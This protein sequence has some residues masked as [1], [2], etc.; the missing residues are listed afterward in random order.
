M[1]FILDED[2][3]FIITNEKG[4]EEEYLYFTA[5]TTNSHGGEEIVI[6]RS[7]FEE[8]GARLVI[9]VEITAGDRRDEKQA[10]RNKHDQS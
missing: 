7:R 5:P 3:G 8:L 4:E 2:S 10:W 6:K 9:K 1:I